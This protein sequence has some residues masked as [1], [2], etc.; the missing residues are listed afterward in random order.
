MEVKVA[1]KKDKR[2]EYCER[3]NLSRTWINNE[4]K[5]FLETGFLGGTMKESSKVL[6]DFL[7]SDVGQSALMIYAKNL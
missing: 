1:Q 2:V 4:L 7:A 3:H 5:L 6:A